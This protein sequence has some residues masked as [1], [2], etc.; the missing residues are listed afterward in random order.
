M[1]ERCSLLNISRSSTLAEKAEE[2]FLPL[3]SISTSNNSSL[4]KVEDTR[5]NTKPQV[6]L[7][8]G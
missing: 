6:F 3:L 8:L 1:A 7:Q 4:F 5:I 2:G